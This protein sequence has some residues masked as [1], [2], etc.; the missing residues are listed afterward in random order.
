MDFSVPIA[1]GI[2]ERGFI[3]VDRARK[4]SLR[5][6]RIRVLHQLGVAGSTHAIAASQTENEKRRQPKARRAC[7]SWQVENP[8]GWDRPELV[9][10][11]HRRQFAYLRP[12]AHF[13]SFS[14]RQ[15]YFCF[16]TRVYT[17]PF[18]SEPPIRSVLSILMETN[19]PQ[20]T[21]T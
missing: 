16:L 11:T 2:L 5:G 1:F 17:E 7:L 12:C 15:C 14:S 13:N 18:P 4:I 20:L 19:F 3:Q 8:P 21:D 9:S 6:F 10:A